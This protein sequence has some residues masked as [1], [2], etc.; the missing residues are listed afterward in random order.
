MPWIVDKPIWTG[1][2]IFQQQSAQYHYS[3][4]NNNDNVSIYGRERRPYNEFQGHIIKCSGQERRP[5]QA[6]QQS[7]T[8]F[9]PE[10]PSFQSIFNSE[11]KKPKLNKKENIIGLTSSNINNRKRN[12]ICHYEGT[13]SRGNLVYPHFLIS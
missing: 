7:V 5:L 9:I 6:L 11:D 4:L 13:D 1:F 12:H 8:D 2:F 3:H 10:T